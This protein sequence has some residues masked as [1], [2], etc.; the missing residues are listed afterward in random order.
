MEGLHTIMKLHW[1]MYMGNGAALV[2]G[3]GIVYTARDV[4]KRCGRYAGVM[5]L[6]AW[7][8]A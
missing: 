3:C 6:R 2:V 1:M 7:L 4:R 8:A 5:W